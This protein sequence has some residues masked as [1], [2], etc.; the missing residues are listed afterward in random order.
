MQY[1]S[2]VYNLLPNLFWS[3]TPALPRGAAGSRLPVGFPEVIP[4]V[5]FIAREV[6]AGDGIEPA[7]ERTR[8]NGFI[9]GARRFHV[10]YGLNPII[11]I[12]SFDD[13]LTRFQAA[14]API[15]RIRLVSHGNDAFIF[16]PVFTNGRWN[17]GMQSD[18]LRALQ[19]SD[20]RGLRFLIS[21][22]AARSPTLI[23]GVSPIVAGIRAL[24][25]AVLAP[26]GLQA[27]G[28]PTG[29]S[30]EY[31]ELVND[32]YQVPHG[33]IVVDNN[34]DAVGDALLSASQQATLTASL[35]L[36]EAEVRRRV[37]GTTPP[38][39]V[40]LTS[41][42]LD[43]LRGAVLGATPAQ[44]GFMGPQRDL[45]AT[46]AA[47]VQAALVAP[48]VEADIRTA[49]RANSTPV[50]ANDYLGGMVLGLQLFR[51]GA[52]NVG[53]AVLDDA[54][55]RADADLEAFALTA[56]DLHHLR[57]V[58]VTINGAP[59][60]AAERAT[61]RQGLIAIADI[62]SARI[63]AATP[64]TTV[65]QLTALRDAIENRPLRESAITGGTLTL[66]REVFTDLAAANTAMQGGFRARLD[67]FRGLM[68]A[69]NASHVDVRGCLVG[70]TP[71]FLVDLR[72]FLGSATNQPTVTA[73]E[74][75]QS[76]PAGFARGPMPAATAFAAI[77]NLVAN[78]NPTQNIDAADVGSNLTTWRG[79][80]DFDPHFDFVAALFAA[81][82]SKRDF[83]SLG[84]RAWRTAATPNG[85]PI[86]RME[87]AR[88]DDLDRLNHLGDVIERFRLLFEIPAASAPNAAARG[89]LDQ[90]QPHVAAFKVTGDAIA[91][92]GAPSQAQ[93]DRF[94]AELSAI[95]T[96]VTA[97]PG[98]P[99][100][101]VPLTPPAAPASLA[102]IQGFAT[103]IANHL[104]TILTNA[105]DPFFV[106]IQGRVADANARIRY[107][108]NIGLPLL[109]QNT[110]RPTSFRI[111]TFGSAP[112]AGAL[113]A[114]MASA[115]RSW[116][117]IQWTGTAPRAAA[118]NATITALPI[119]NDTERTAAS[120][121]SML[122]EDDDP[123]TN[124]GADAGI[125]PMQTFHDHI[126]TRPP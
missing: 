69:A 62:I 120:Q 108:Y 125:S 95:A 113:S 18:L 27:A 101:A 75:F 57:N 60:T 121:V 86:L 78:G 34:G 96:A 4:E 56:I 124:P 64:A 116:M 107:F 63:R 109:I 102:D 41:G 19:S 68:G 105:L 26:F 84:W 93:L 16:L 85:I 92:A 12:N 24:S 80:I 58:G 46:A 31:F 1:R 59:S 122:S 30:Q 61:I 36:I 106:A 110:T 33:T 22:D 97:I 123:I 51:P 89:R 126:V 20:E 104:D 112:T 48:R 35:N 29:A 90:L 77:D 14:T 42:H 79:L 73:P 6:R 81:G 82:A 47:D 50:L 119:T 83:A 43:A 38:G 98:F 39:G 17:L 117:R 72:T 111:T 103:S 15:E 94:L 70:K 53:G 87:A 5:T 8:L 40:A 23:D 100:P 9:Q 25:G 88:V 45:A 32:L 3:I 66:S 2:L 7:A 54:A 76:F 44:L 91:A 37:V 55:F 21:G 114:L 99:A 49:I 118:M 11:T 28:N 52:L 74:W 65:A 13:I 67:H 115:F 71:A 10:L